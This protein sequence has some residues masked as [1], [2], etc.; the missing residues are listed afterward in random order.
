MAQ[1][2]HQ[3]QDKLFKQAMAD[4]RVAEAFFTTHLP[5][6]LLAQVDLTSLSLTPHS[7]IDEAY[8][9]TEADVVYQVLLHG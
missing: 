2:I 1:F 6:E 7:F 3:P 4:N 9:A 5:D 8:K